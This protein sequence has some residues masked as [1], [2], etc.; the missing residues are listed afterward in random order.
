MKLS[1]D[2]INVLKNF[3]SINPNIV[4]KPG[5]VLATISEAKNIYA[6]CTVPEKFETQFGI[7]DLNEFLSALSLVEDP[8]LSFGESSV[9]FKSGKTSVQYYYADQSV[10][11]APSKPITMPKADVKLTLSEESIGKI[12]KASSVLGHSTLVI[13]G[14]DGVIDLSIVDQKNTT[15]NKYT[16]RLDDDNACK[17]KF[18][19]VIVIGNLKMLNG[20]YEV[21]LSSK[22]ISHFKSLTSPAEYFIAIEK[23]STFEK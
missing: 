14:E 7:Y 12:K 13:S 3:A 10:L 17:N 18:S 4:V 22:L 6:S 2:T 16:L 23:N 5:S 15:G 20:T 8:D 11:T 19:F 21:Y 1:P 9:I